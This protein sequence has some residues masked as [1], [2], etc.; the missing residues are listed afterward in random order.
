MYDLVFIHCLNF[1][2]YVFIQTTVFIPVIFHAFK[3]S[4][5]IIYSRQF[6]LLFIQIQIV[7]I[8]VYV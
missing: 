6:N 5:P 1:R 7:F 4:Q 2:F 8:L 3:L